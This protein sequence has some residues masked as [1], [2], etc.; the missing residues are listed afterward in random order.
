MPTAT[1]NFGLSKPLVNNPTDQD[2]WGGYVNTDLDS[3]DGLLETSLNWTPS[4]KSGTITVTAPTAASTTTGSAKIL[5]LCDA[6]GGAFAANLP[7][8]STCSGMAVAF[9]K[10]DATANA[11]TV[12]PNGADKIDGAASYIINAQ[13]QYLIIS[14]DGTNWDIL[15]VTPPSVSIPTASTTVAGILM[16]STAALALTGT[17]I[18]TALTP[19]AFAGNKSLAGNGY[20][21]FPGGL[22]IQW[23]SGTAN[24]SASTAINFPIS[25]PNA[26]YQVSVTDTAGTGGTVLT[27]SAKNLSSVTITN[28]NG[29]N[30]T[31]SIIAIGT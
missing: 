17:D 2:L 6:A 8:A 20:Y 3:I 23:C 25:F 31:V 5:Y 10:I 1:T 22:I 28:G 11:I 26:I 7:A 30:H 4:S 14:S 9:K 18:A 13:Y 21:K 29:S 16:T 27:A 15:S 19:S 24:A 12:T